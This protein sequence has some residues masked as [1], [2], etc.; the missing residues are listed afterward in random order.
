MA[1]EW[2]GGEEG[3][4]KSRLIG[5]EVKKGEIGA[6]QL[7]SQLCRNAGDRGEGFCQK[8]FPLRPTTTHQPGPLE[9][10]TKEG[11]FASGSSSIFRSQWRPWPP[12]RI[13]SRSLEFVSFPPPVP[14]QQRVTPRHPTH[15][16]PGPGSV[17][18]Q[19]G[20]HALHTHAPLHLRETLPRASNPGSRDP[21]PH[22]SRLPLLDRSWSL[23]RCPLGSSPSLLSHVSVSERNPSSTSRENQS[24]SSSRNELSLCRHSDDFQAPS[25]STPRQPYPL[26]HTAE[27][28]ALL[29]SPISY[30]DGM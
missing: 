6:V 15:H 20:T 12:D 9:L 8:F 17:A 30:R 29:A 19:P 28:I 2:S 23:F 10:Q 27:R 7:N 14:T 4:S 5:S 21:P 18:D 13:W 3:S 24:R 22:T 11:C 1:V 25:F 16:A 26:P